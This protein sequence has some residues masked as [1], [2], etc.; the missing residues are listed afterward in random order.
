MSGRTIRRVEAGHWW[1]H[2]WLARLPGSVQQ[3]GLRAWR[4]SLV[5]PAWSAEE[6]L[7]RI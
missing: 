6:K 4:L 7:V 1:L 5:Q 2:R 3:R